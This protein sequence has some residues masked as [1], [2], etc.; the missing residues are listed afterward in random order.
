[1]SEKSRIWKSMYPLFVMI[2]LSSLLIVVLGF[3]VWQIPEPYPASKYE[4]L[5]TRLRAQNVSFL[6]VHDCDFRIDGIKTFME[7]EKKMNVSAIYFLRPD[8]DYFTQS[9]PYFQSLNLTFGFHYGCLS[10]AKGNVGF[11]TQ[12]FT[13]ELAFMRG[14]LDIR[15]VRSHGDN[16]DLTINNHDLVNGTLWA[17]L[18][19]TDYSNEEF[20]AQGYS[21]ISDTNHV[22][23]EPETLGDR[24]LV[25][26]HS[27]YW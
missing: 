18:G 14:F 16:Y 17:Q 27:D 4:D 13:S 25:N 23:H 24:V 7:V 9:I 8:S 5:I 19:L 3:I 12:L 6:V 22:W 26:L 1:M 10:R 20:V 11:A 21:Y 15:F 2:A